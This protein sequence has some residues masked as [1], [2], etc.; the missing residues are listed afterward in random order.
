MRQTNHYV[1]FFHF[2]INRIVVFDKK[3]FHLL[4]ENIGSRK[5]FA[6]ADAT[7]FLYANLD[8]VCE[9]KICILHISTTSALTAFAR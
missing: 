1:E 6:S 5:I 3:D 2:D 4:F 7:T 9:N 8:S